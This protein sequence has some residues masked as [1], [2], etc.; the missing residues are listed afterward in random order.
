MSD[1]ERPDLY[2]VDDTI[3]LELEFLTALI[4]APDPVTAAAVHAMIG[5]E[6]SDGTGLPVDA[7]LFL[8]PAHARVFA[9]VVARVGDGA[10]VTPTLL[11]EGL[12]DPKARAG[13]REVLLEIGAPTGQGPL[14]GGADVPHL[15]IA[16]IDHWYRRG[17]TALLSRMALACEESPTDDL[18]DRWAELTIHQQTAHRCRVEVRRRLTQV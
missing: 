1:D 9:N 18:A 13:L 17:Y 7:A 3:R 12:T 16:V 5:T 14:P 10:P 4:W 6:R 2:P 11:A 8:R 15:A